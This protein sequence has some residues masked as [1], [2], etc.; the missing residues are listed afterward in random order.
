MRFL[1]S[2]CVRAPPPVWLTQLLLLFVQ[3]QL[4]PSCIVVLLSGGQRVKIPQRYLP[5]WLWSSRV[6]SGHFT[7]LVSHHS[8][9]SRRRWKRRSEGVALFSW[10]KS[11]LINA[12]LCCH[13]KLNSQSVVSP[14]LPHE[15]DQ[16]SAVQLSE[17]AR[18][19]KRVCSSL[20]DIL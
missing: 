4:V 12:E 2:V 6:C 17:S 9:D 10:V 3:V 15:R 8:H 16:R 7:V 18:Q 11:L 14:R 13:N 19:P 5:L 20:S 1:R